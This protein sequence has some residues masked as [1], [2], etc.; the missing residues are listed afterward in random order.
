M[1]GD[2]ILGTKDKY[3]VGLEKLAFAESQVSEMQQELSDLQPKLVVA[4]E[5]NAK[6]TAQIEKDSIEAADM[7][8]VRVQRRV[9]AI[10]LG[11][12]VMQLL[13]RLGLGWWYW[14]WN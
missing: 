13:A 1:T 7:E 5:E 9:H 11:G 3:V 8:K 10:S 6:M 4:Q 2:D 14:R 12:G